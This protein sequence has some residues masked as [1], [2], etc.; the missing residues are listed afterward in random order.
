[1]NLTCP[2]CSFIPSRA[3]HASR[4]H[5]A[6]T[7]FR[8]CQPLILPKPK[9]TNFPSL[10]ITFYPSPHTMPPRKSDASKVATA[11]EATP[12]KDQPA[13]RDGINIEVGPPP[14]QAHTHIQSS[15]SQLAS[16]AKEFPYQYAN[17]IK[18][19]QYRKEPNAHPRISTS[20]RA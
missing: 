15:S 8:L 5:H 17:S 4:S 2:I 10:H 19:K 16:A 3:K 14:S 6:L 13:M 11:D 9:F 12:A 20:R 1:M 7:A 18:W